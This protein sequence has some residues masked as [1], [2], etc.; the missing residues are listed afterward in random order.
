MR[1]IK[2]EF[3][4][5]IIGDEKYRVEFD[6]KN[7]QY[8]EVTKTRLRVHQN[9][10]DTFELKFSPVLSQEE[11]K[12][13]QGIFQSAPPIDNF[14]ETDAIYHRWDTRVPLERRS[15]HKWESSDPRK[16]FPKTTETIIVSRIHEG[17][18][19][20]AIATV[21]TQKENYFVEVNFP[22]DH[23][24]IGTHKKIQIFGEPLA[25]RRRFE[26]PAPTTTESDWSKDL[27]WLNIPYNSLTWHRQDPREY[28]ASELSQGNK[29]MPRYLI[30]NSY[31]FRRSLLELGVLKGPFELK[32]ADWPTEDL[33]SSREW[34]WLPF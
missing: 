3:D 15:C 30:M 7:I 2:Q 12:R 17:L 10:G 32:I 19:Q 22:N 33:N 13:V 5:A 24:I 16:R 28:W 4:K 14:E 11:I 18:P 1:T 31:H 9:E 6:I 23:I 20:F 27:K 8:F 29:I 21:N 25:Y 26:D 34:C